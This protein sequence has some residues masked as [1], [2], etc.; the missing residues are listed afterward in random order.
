MVSPMRGAD[1]A[2]FCIGYIMTCGEFLKALQDNPD[3]ELV[4]EKLMEPVREGSSCRLI[5]KF[6][7]LDIKSNEFELI[8]EYN[9]Y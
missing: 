4:F 1:W 6:D 7:N 8:I 9:P 5:Q 2:Q 3:K